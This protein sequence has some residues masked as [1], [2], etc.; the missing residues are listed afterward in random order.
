MRRLEQVRLEDAPAGPDAGLS[1]RRALAAAEARLAS[2]PPLV[3]AGEARK[4][5]AQLALASEGRAFLLQGGDCAES[6]AEFSAD[7]I[8]DTFKVMLQMAVVLTFGAKCPVVKVGRIAGQFAKPRSAPT[9]SMGGVELP[10]Y[11]GDIV[12]GFEFTPEARVPDPARM[13]QAYTQSAATLNLLRA[14]SQGGYADINR[15]HSWTLDFTAG[16]GGLRA[17][18]QARQPHLRRARLHGRRRASARRPPTRC[19]GSTSTPRTRRCCSSTRR[20]SA[21]STRPPACRWRARGT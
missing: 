14:F 2:Y 15:V 7:N 17:V 3:F 4:L 12:N 16:P 18:P 8:R 1:R 21:A 20:R 11:R 13:L 5:K 6:F 19:T 10:S 9:E